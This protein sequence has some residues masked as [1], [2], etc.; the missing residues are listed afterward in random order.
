MK[1][2]VY[3]YADFN[4]EALLRLSEQHRGRPCT[5]DISQMP[6]SGSLNW[7]IFI[8]FDDGIEWVFR[9]P[10]SGLHSFYSD[11]TASKIVVSEASTLMYL[12]AYTSVP[13]PE[14]Y[15][16][17]GSSDNDIGVPY[18]LQSKAAGRSLGSYDWSQL[19]RV[20]RS[21]NYRPPLPL[22]DKD[23]EKIMSQLGTIMSELSDHRFEKIGSIFNDGNGGYFV[24][25]CLSPSLTW[26]ERDSLDLERGPFDEEHDYFKS[27]ISAFT[28]HA[29][30]LPLTPHVFFAPVPDIQDYK[31]IAS[32]NIASRRWNDFVAIG[33]K[34]DHS[35]NMLFYSIAGQ[36]LCE[37]IPRL[38]C[39][40]RTSFTLSHPDL[41]PGNIYVDDDL[42]ITCIIDWSSAS[43]GPITEVLA[44]PSLGGSATPPSVFLAAAFR[45][46]FS[47]RASK[48]A[49]DLLH[50]NLWETSERI[51]SF[52][53]LVRLLSKN[54]HEHFRRLFELV[55][56]TGAEEAR[57]SIGIL[58]LFHERANWDENK[59]LLAEL[60]GEDITAEELQKDERACFPPQRTTDSDA[61][62]VARKLTLM[63]EM[64][65][66]FLADHRLWQCVEEARKH[67]CPL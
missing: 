4:L 41:H 11:E 28:S 30:E 48:V 21:P 40:L 43:S 7:V 39:G 63:S 62:A 52:S 22:S 18:I 50:L 33:Q 1:D 19:P 17:S 66:G 45:S 60:Q 5:C 15:S 58:W 6:K 32:Y 26:Q 14:V 3:N 34:V 8:S 54:D 64:N 13:V 29:Q 42:N 25:E 20:S 59:T 37:M 49:P 36:F 55:Y 2:K 61:I 46:G 27:L 9:S 67:E 31:S 23:R 57:S 38:I 53:R 12:K 10:R 16:Y 24:G 51:W 65:P 47:R 56:E 35:K 44:T